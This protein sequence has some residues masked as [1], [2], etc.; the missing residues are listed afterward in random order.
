[1]IT[2]TTALTAVFIA[3]TAALD[4]IPGAVMADMVL[5][6]SRDLASD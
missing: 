2:T 6:T 1:M 5:A 3:L 4:T